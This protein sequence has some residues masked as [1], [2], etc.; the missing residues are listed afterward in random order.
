MFSI[1]R[2]FDGKVLHMTGNVCKTNRC[3]FPSV[4]K[5]LLRDVNRYHILMAQNKICQFQ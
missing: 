1:M 3:P 2:I 5:T 4:Y